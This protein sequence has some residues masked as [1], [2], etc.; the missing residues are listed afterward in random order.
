MILKWLLDHTHGQALDLMNYDFLL[1]N[2]MQALCQCWHT[3]ENIFFG[4]Y[5]ENSPR[6]NRFIMIFFE[7]S[8]VS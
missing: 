8:S 2:A 3:K 1:G 7:I 6:A 5:A 4:A